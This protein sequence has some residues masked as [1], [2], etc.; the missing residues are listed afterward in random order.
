MPCKKLIVLAALGLACCAMPGA[1]AQNAAAAATAGTLVVVPAFGEVKRANDEVTLT[2]SVEEQD[3]DRAL[4][5]ARLNRKMKEGVEIVRRADPSAEL[6][7]VR[8]YTIP[9]YPELPN[10]PRPLTAQE[11]A[12]RSVPIGWRV[13]QEL[14]VHTRDLG[15]LPKVVA[16]AQ[17]V[18]AWPP[19]ATT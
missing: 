5:T 9:V 16:A 4:A 17:K 1:Q 3:K 2:L 13:S 14:E 12:A 6:K 19:S 11:Q 18:L 8:Y 15:N 10:P 7:T